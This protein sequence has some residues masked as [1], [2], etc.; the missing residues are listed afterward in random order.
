MCYFNDTVIRAGMMVSTLMPIVA[1]GS[2]VLFVLAVNPLLIRFR[3][4]AALR[5]PEAAM[6]LVLFLL[7]CGIPGWGLVQ[8]F[9]GTVMFPHHDARITPGWQEENILAVAPPQMLADVSKDESRALDGYVTGL[10]EG[11]QHISPLAVPWNAWR[12]TFLFWGPL[13]VSMLIA[14][15]GLAAVFHRQWSRHEQ[16]PYP[17][18]VFAHALLPDPSGK[19]NPIFRN[20]LFWVGFLLSFLILMNN[21]M[22][23]WWPQ[24]VIPIP[25]RLNFSPLMKLFPLLVKGK[26]WLLFYPQILFPVV[27]LAYFLPSDVSASMCIAPFA[28]CLIGGIFA[29]YGIEL[30]AGKMMALS[31]EPFIFAGGYF[32]ILMM[33]LY[34]G[35]HYYWSTLRAGFG[36][37]VRSGCMPLPSEFPQGK[38]LGTG[39]ASYPA[40]SRTLPTS[41]STSGW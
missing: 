37:P 1:Y 33:L 9:P 28:Y 29:G 19:A 17:I 15:L 23:R 25:L 34:T 22:H 30:R 2:L 27:G 31:I 10:A 18:P 26:G 6:I 12:R 35:R 40:S 24:A 8:L 41:H 11:D 38:L 20:T 14:V 16:L 32:A 39:K 36:L 13:A 4:G 3:R 7:A 5:G 21:Y